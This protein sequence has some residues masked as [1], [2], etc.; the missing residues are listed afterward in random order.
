MRK[1]ANLLEKCARNIRKTTIFR[2]KKCQCYRRNLKE[3]SKVFFRNN[4]RLVV[5]FFS[6][7][8]QI[9]TTQLF[10]GGGNY[11]RIRQGAFCQ[12]ILNQ[13]ERICKSNQKNDNFRQK[14]KKST[15]EMCKKYL[16]HDNFQRIQLVN[17]LKIASLH[18]S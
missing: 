9:T 17:I 7:L 13:N 3:N 10:C 16:K 12:I 2:P 18:V 15:G 1:K 5:Y 6:L 8:L 4:R 14:N 11:T